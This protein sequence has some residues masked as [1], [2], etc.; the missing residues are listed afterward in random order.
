MKIAI[1]GAGAM[2]GLFGARLA[3]A[4]FNISLIEYDNSAIQVI[5]EK[6]VAL[7]T[8]GTNLYVNVPIGRALDFK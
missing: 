1:I 8:A 7:E 3:L 2:G 6:G 5:K 4:G